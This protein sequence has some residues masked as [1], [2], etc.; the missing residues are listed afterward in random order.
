MNSFSASVLS[1]SSPPPAKRASPDR[2]ADLIEEPTTIALRR[3]IR[4]EDLPDSIGPD[5]PFRHHPKYQVNFLIPEPS[6]KQTYLS[7]P[8]NSAL[9]AFL[10]P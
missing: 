2:L 8:A 1:V 9:L 5:S 7:I 6:S 10:I 4:D 3:I